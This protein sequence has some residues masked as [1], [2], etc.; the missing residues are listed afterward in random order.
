[1]PSFQGGKCHHSKGENVIILRENSIISKRGNPIISE[2]GNSIIS[3]GE[4]S[5]QRGEMSS[6]PQE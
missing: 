4:M 6:S 2:G 1:M 3:R 5:F